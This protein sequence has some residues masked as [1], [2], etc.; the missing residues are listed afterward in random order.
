[1]KTLGIDIGGS[2]IK[3]AIVD[4]EKGTLLTER[5]R[6]ETPDDST[7]AT[8]GRE[9]RAL[10]KHFKWTGPVGLG[11]PG[12]IRNNVIHTA[13]NL[14]EGWIGLNLAA[15][16]T[17]AT[18]CPAQVVNDADAAGLAETAFGAGRDRRGTVLLLTLGTGIGSAIICNGKL[19][20]NTEFGHLEFHDGS[21]E[22]YA[23]AS[24]RKEKDLRWSHWSKR[25]N[26]ALLHLDYVLSPELIILGGGVS[27]KFDK[28]AAHFDKSL[29]V[30]PAQMLNE[31]G[32]IG[33]ALAAAQG[34]AGRKRS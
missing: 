33:A 3:A 5:E 34:L 27:A 10:I 11:F 20:P 4:V 2:G 32:I 25:V 31:A 6:R 28:M 21:L 14:D 12:V 24:V 29:N 23:A 7:P 13:V 19:V 17:Q 9:I 8:V 15:R 22:D 18:K 30:V 26:K 16:V 1:M